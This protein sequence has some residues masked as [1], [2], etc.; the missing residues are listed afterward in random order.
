M[1]LNFRNCNNPLKH[2]LTKLC[3]KRIKQTHNWTATPWHLQFKL[4]AIDKKIQKGFNLLKQYDVIKYD[5][6]R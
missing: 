1:H 2:P 4:Y 6:I 5:E 3:I